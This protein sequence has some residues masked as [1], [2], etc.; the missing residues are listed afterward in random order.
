MKKIASFLLIIICFVTTTS[1]IH[2]ADK[3][4]SWTDEELAFM[5]DHPVINLGA[6]P[7]FVPF[8]FF[9]NDGEYKGIAAEYIAIIEDK[10][11]L[12]F[13]V[14]ENL[15]WQ[16][17]YD[18]ALSGEIDALPA[19]SKTPER[20]K[21]FIF[22]EAY[23]YFK[24]VIVTLDTN[25]S[26][27]DI[28]D[29]EKLTVAVQK[30][31]SHHSY[32]LDYPKINLSLYDSVEEALT[33]VAN[34]TEVAFVGNLATTNY[35]IKS[36]AL[37]NLKFTAFEAEKKQG[38]HFAV[39]KDYSVLVD[40]ID[41]VLETITE[42][43]KIAINNK[44]IDLKTDTDYTPIIKVI[45]I[46]VSVFAIILIVSTYWI[47]KLRKEIKKRK[48][49]QLDLEKAK[50]EAEEAN[51]FKSSFMARMSHEI[52]TPLNAIT[53]M[54]YLLKKT[55]ITLTQSMY[56][57]RI[58][59]A[60]N[61][62]LSIINDILDFS[63]IE[64]GKVE[65][66]ITSFSMD[67]AIQNVV[68]I[69]S[70]KIEE[71][72][73]GFRLIKDPSI[74]N[75]FL[76]D[77]KRIEQILI[78]LLNNASKFTSKG[79]VSLE[80]RLIAKE[81]EKCHLAFIVKDTG[82]GMTKEQTDKLFMPFVQ[83]DSSI[84]RRFGG[85]GLGL[86]IVKNLVELMGG[87]IKVYSTINEGTTFIVNITLDIDTEKQSEYTKSI[88]AEHFKDVKTLVLEKSG[89]NMNLIESYLGSFGMH[90]ELTTSKE[91][92]IRMLESEANSY[93]KSFDLFIIDYD[94]PIEGGINFVEELRQRKIIKMPK[95]IMLLPMLRADLFDNLKEHNIDFGIVKP[96][97]P[98][99]LF[100]GIVEIFNL[101]A[102]NA[103]RRNVNTKKEVDSEKRY[104][105]LLAED[106]KTNQLIAKTLLEKEGI[107]VLIANDGNEAVESF[108]KNKDNISLILMDLHMPNLN[109][110]D[111]SKLIR[112][113]DKE[114]TIIALTADVI[115]GVKSKCEESG[116]NDYISKPFD[117]DKFIEKIKD[118]IKGS[119]KELAKESVKASTGKS[120][121]G[122]NVINQD[123]TI[124]NIE[125]SVLNLQEGIK[126]L[127]GNK[128][129]Y[130][131][132]I[133]EYFVENQD[134]N[135]KLAEM[136]NQKDY[137]TAIQI[138]HKV[139]SSSSSIGSNKLYNISK[140]LQ[141]A[142]KDEDENAI[143]KESEEFFSTL[144]EVMLII[145]KYLLE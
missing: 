92:A 45:V 120:N 4:I 82:I 137:E 118:A 34:G 14:L 38:I 129:A 114:I 3:N 48:Q 94:T 17:A 125:A 104:Q 27:K 42:E 86:S 30:N 115:L 110:Y 85:S 99:I 91:S 126:N 59:Q 144:K 26:I 100:N 113:K 88:S 117:P 122:L 93:N 90:C 109:G 57:D 7:F 56:T 108:A 142:L 66:E 65:L 21:S 52:R 41:K 29:L 105:I 11:G 138:V 143:I 135:E 80:I 121:E 136:I 16:E 28:K 77:S 31:S 60:A 8:E 37:T 97:I 1:N 62:M 19:I 35:L 73:I 12:K 24:R 89:A 123:K 106:N 40:I 22:S 32:L 84:N 78:N 46:I 2:A 96:I 98:S 36:N 9:D 49:I 75:W 68:N 54:A 69:A 64:S 23:Y 127:G 5:E 72:E 103:S 51:E 20:E 44:W 102:I 130:K 131:E 55:D 139:K 18:M 132:V 83:A 39:R 71:Q 79:E 124:N 50:K 33:S 107:N 140:R 141:I 116:I 53:G 119:T 76:G 58:T 61:N 63:K 25:S 43:E 10:T 74:P 13:N 70:Y 95:I 133:Y 128:E 15:S 145:K 112:E 134:T 81:N 111:A 101:K 47:V 6:D 87:E 67:Q